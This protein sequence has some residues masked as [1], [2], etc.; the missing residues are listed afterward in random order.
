MAVLAELVRSGSG[1]KAEA[2]VLGGDE[3][4]EEARSQAWGKRG[5]W[6][7]MGEVDVWRST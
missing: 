7:W 2:V 4:V 3:Q 1:E 6:F 5:I